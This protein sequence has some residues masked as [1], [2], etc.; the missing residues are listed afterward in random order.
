MTSQENAVPTWFWI[1]AGLAVV[2]NLIG[3]SAFIADLT[4]SAEDIAKFPQYAQD[5]YAMRPSWALVA[6]GFAVLGGLLGSIL[7]VLRKSMATT[8]LLVSLLAILVQDVFWYGMAKTHLTHP[9]ADH[10]LPVLVITIAILLLWFARSANG[11]GWL[12]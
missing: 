5:A 2:W 6:F 10:I 12:Q 3:A 7:L 4:R 9:P 11:K 1:V 8:V